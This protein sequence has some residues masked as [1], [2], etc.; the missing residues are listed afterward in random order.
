[1]R[2]CIHRQSA[3]SHNR[4][5]AQDRVPNAAMRQPD[6]IRVTALCQ[7]SAVGCAV[8]RGTGI[9][10]AIL[11]IWFQLIF[12]VLGPVTAA[13]ADPLAHD[14]SAHCAAVEGVPTG[15]EQHHAGAADHCPLCFAGVSTTIV[16]DRI[17][18]ASPAIL[19]IPIQHGVSTDWIRVHRAD[20]DRAPARAPPFRC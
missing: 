12:H 4:N 2:T 16:P 3:Q 11:G 14:L 19:S 7:P 5:H 9:G 20:Y 18:L 10:L 15:H 13:N 6:T 1:M 17:G 8:L